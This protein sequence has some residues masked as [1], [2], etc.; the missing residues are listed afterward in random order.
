[1]ISVN[2]CERG[3]RLYRSDRKEKIWSADDIT[4]FCT[5]ASPELQ[6]ALIA[7]LWLGQRQGDLLRL[8]WTNYDGTFVRLRQSKSKKTGDHSCRNA[9]QDRLNLDQHPRQTVDLGR[10]QIVLGQG[11]CQGKDRR[12][13]LS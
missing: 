6:L 12:P 9:A 10:V 7:A 11:V 5:V 3:G 8:A 2:V 4:A 1:M 13:D